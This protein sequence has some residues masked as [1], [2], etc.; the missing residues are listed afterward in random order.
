MQDVFARRMYEYNC[1]ILD[2]IH[3][4][5]SFSCKSQRNYWPGCQFRRQNDSVHSSGS[6]W[7][8]LMMTAVDKK[9]SVMKS[10]VFATI[11]LGKRLYG[12]PVQFQCGWFTSP[13]VD[14]GSFG[15]E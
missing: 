10:V 9:G 4:V 15:I 7:L 6:R 1:A 13:D 12:H 14:R 11:L 3:S 5:N 2:P 8:E